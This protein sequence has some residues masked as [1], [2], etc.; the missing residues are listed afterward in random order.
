MRHGKLTQGNGG[1]S[2]ITVFGSINLDLI[3]GVERL[4]RPGETVPGSA[5]V[6]APGGKGANQALAAARADARV[7]MVG[8]VGRDSFASEALQLLRAGGLDLSRVREADAPTGVAL[9]LVDGSGENVIAVI[10]GANGTMSAA[11]AAA[12]EFSPADVLLLQLEVPV[13]AIEAAATRARAAGAKVLLNFA[14]YRADAIGLLDRATH[15]VVNETECAWIAGAESIAA[16]TPEQQA[17]ALAKRRGLVVAVTL[18]KDGVL[19]AHGSRIER[20]P[21]LPVKPVDTVGAGDSFCGYLA[22]GLSEGLLLAE[23]LTLG[24]AAGSL[25]C[26]KSGAQ[27]SIPLRAE[28]D[29][30]VDRPQE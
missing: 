27:P 14:P 5:F 18:G 10:P 1:A 16:D 30:A 2:V 29:A 19:A 24:A 8:A 22:A 6:T 21:A 26:T 9:I 3:G 25:A 4:P 7:R 23:A 11:D 13:A 17:T 28:V 15:L 12:L 20:A